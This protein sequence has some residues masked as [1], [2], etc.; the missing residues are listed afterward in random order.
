MYPSKAVTLVFIA[1]AGILFSSSILADGALN[2][3]AKANTAMV[4]LSEGQKKGIKVE[5]VDEHAFPQE[6][7]AIGTIDFNQELLTLVFAPYQGRILKAFAS[8]GDKVEKDQVL[9]TIDSPDLVQAVST[10]ISAAGVLELNSKA[11]VRQRNL[12][13]QGAAARKDYEQA[14]SDQQGA[15]G[16]YKAAR[17]AVKVFGKTDAD[18]DKMVEDR[19]IDP[20]LVVLSPISGLV[21]QRNAAP[22]L[23]VQPG[24]AS[25]VYTVADTAKMWMLANVPEKDAPAVK[26]GQE[27]RAEVELL[28]G[29]VFLGKIVTVDATVDPNTRRVLIRSEIAD[30]SAE[31]RAGMFAMF[32]IAIAPP[33]LA[34]AVPREGVVREGNGTMSVWVTADR[35]T[36]TKRTVKTG[37]NHDGYV[38][39]IGGVQ[40]GQLVA[41]EGALFISNTYA[42]AY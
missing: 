24:N 18:I 7:T 16:A 40:R 27:V 33:K 10:L 25:P 20:A 35:H 38:E 34:L 23:L 39:V 29:R 21:T 1:F 26:I 6:K 14:V 11:L 3:P 8:V 37:L 9:F 30:P 41:T 31:L 19:A 17:A 36:F 2:A 42:S 4:E 5:E 32:A 22:G 15:E 13:G 12:Y 28:P